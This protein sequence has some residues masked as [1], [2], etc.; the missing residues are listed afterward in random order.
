[1]NFNIKNANK[2]K[3]FIKNLAGASNIKDMQVEL[4]QNFDI[5]KFHK[6]LNNNK[7]RYLNLN[8]IKIT[9]KDIVRLIHI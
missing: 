2:T 4:A 5:C 7:L 1:M 9:L 3:Y 6:S 8:D